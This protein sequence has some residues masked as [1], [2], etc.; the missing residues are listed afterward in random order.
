MLSFS[1]KTET[2]ARWRADFRLVDQLPDV[3]VVRTKF[4]VNFASLAIMTTLFAI[5]GYREFTKI[6]LRQSVEMLQNEVD[7]RSS[8]NRRLTALSGDF[9][10][11]SNKMV[12]IRELAKAPVRPAALLVE[13]ARLRTP[14]IVFDTISYEQYWDNA[15]AAHTFK[16][17]LDGKGRTT[18]DIAE[19]KN[20]L[21]ILEMADGWEV[22][23][24]EEGNPSKDSTS[25]VF[26][27]II[28]LIITEVKD[29]AN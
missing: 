18:A 11:L 12:D 6:S 4:I 10:R 16:V 28:A 3:K 7:T 8:A 29:A 27:F 21:M 13:L 20:R 22:K 1:K 19:L 25:G 24:V 2:K 15:A 5:A 14:D 9:R 23:V 26:S 17:R